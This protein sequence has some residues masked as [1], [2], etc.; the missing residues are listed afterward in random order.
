MRMWVHLLLL[1]LCLGQECEVDGDC[2]EGNPCCS[3]FGFCGSGEGFC[4]RARRV[5]PAGRPPT[6]TQGEAGAGPG[7]TLANTELVGGDLSPA[8]GGGGIT[9]ER[10]EAQECFI[11][12]EEHPGCKWFT[13]D[14]RAARCYLK[15]SRGYVRERSD[16]FTSGATFRD[17]CNQEAE[18]E[19]PYTR[20]V[21]GL[22]L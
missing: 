9:L 12:C 11:R 1:P 7:C 5:G 20:Q 4:T 2:G 15:S 18:C 6:N 8:A 22:V 13:W 14:E 17:G 10:G 19:N 16:G 3:G 21:A